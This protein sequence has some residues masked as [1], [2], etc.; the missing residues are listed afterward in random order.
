MN[1]SFLFNALLWLRRAQSIDI[2]DRLASILRD[3][4]G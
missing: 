1:Q 3:L 4:F 2:F